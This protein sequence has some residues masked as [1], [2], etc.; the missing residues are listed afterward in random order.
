MLGGGEWKVQDGALRQ[1][2]SK[3]NIRATAGQKDWADYTYSLKAR[4]LGGAE[5]FLILFGV[6]DDNQKAW[7]NIGGW[8]NSRHAIEMGGIMGNEV[9]GKIETGRWYDIRVE[10]KGQQIQCYLD[11]KLV[12][13]IT[14]PPVKSLVAT[15]SRDEASGEL[16]LKVVN[17]TSTA[18]E[19]DLQF[20][21]LKRVT[22]PAR[23]LV[24]ASEKPTD[25]NTLDH[26]KLV[27]PVE[28]NLTI[29]GTKLRHNFP[30][31]SVTI[32]RMKAE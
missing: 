22:G 5:G 10:V 1:T 29:D 14:T 28:K 19:T 27:A 13:D 3:E 26:P 6:R 16:I 11:G 23:A 9:P 25:E 15:A 21:G 2:G 12:H 30:G 20:N 8:G 18:Q 4:K 17:V 31:N 24:L 7:W 32:L